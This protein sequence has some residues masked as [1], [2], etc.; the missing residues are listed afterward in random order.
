[1]IRR[2]RELTQLSEEEIRAIDVQIETAFKIIEGDFRDELNDFLGSHGITEKL[3]KISLSVVKA[4]NDI[5]GYNVQPEVGMITVI[6]GQVAMSQ[7]LTPLAS[8]SSLYFS[9]TPENPHFDF[10]LAC[11][12]RQEYFEVLQLHHYFRNHPSQGAYRAGMQPQMKKAMKDF[13]SDV[14]TPA[15]KKKK[16]S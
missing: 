1:C 13:E 6:K 11:L 8:A 4:L 2:A 3:R 5:D 10:I 7:P 14:E 12:S 9:I 16:A 15:V